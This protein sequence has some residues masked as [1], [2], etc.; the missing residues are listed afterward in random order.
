[1]TCANTSQIRH[2]PSPGK[3]GFTQVQVPISPTDLRSPVES[4]F[5]H[6]SDS[7]FDPPRLEDF[8]PLFKSRNDYTRRLF[9]RIVR[10]S[11]GGQE[12]KVERRTWEPVL[13]VSVV[14]S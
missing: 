7:Y 1:M 13:Q 8:E 6:P 14:L 2:S 9:Y 3:R 10:E 4:D 11:I 12:G 5:H